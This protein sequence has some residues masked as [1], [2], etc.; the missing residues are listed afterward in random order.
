MNYYQADQ[1]K[2]EEHIL[3]LSKSG[4]KS[5]RSDCF[6]E[7]VTQIDGLAKDTVYISNISETG[8]MMIV[9]QGTSIPEEFQLLG[10][11]KEPVNCRKVWQKNENIGVKFIEEKQNH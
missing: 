6:L 8:L 10:L 9:M 3:K 11:K 1:S 7:A 5:M 4:R 2:F